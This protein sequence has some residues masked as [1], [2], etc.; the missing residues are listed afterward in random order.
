MSQAEKESVAG[1]CFW[2]HM[3]RKSAQEGKKRRRSGDICRPATFSHLTCDVS[4]FDLRRRA[5]TLPPQWPPY[6]FCAN[7]ARPGLASCLFMASHQ[8]SGSRE[9]QNT[10]WEAPMPGR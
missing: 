9:C 5:A 6:S 4:L 3:R 1:L 7:L 8:R 2:L 10:I